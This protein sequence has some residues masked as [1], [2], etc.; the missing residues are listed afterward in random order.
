MKKTG[1]IKLL[2]AIIPLMTVFVT[3][4]P[5]GV[6]FFDGTAVTYSNWLQ[7]AIQS[8]MAWCA[9]VASV[10]NY[11]VFGLAVI[12]L[13]TKKSKSV[14]AIFYLA[15]VA[16]CIASLPVVS[17]GDVKIVPNVLGIILLGVECIIA[18]V[19]N[20]KEQ[21]SQDNAPK[22]ERLARH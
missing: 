18:A 6:M 22:G 10:L 17:S 20:K 5:D 7:P 15:L 13:V 16:T 8:G 3:S 11:L 9:P 2:L 4:S 14:K 1:F 19:L 12:Y 21:D